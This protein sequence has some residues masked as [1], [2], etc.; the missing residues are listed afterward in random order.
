MSSFDI[1]AAES[2]D[3][4]ESNTN[5]SNKSSSSTCFKENLLGTTKVQKIK[6]NVRKRKKTVADYPLLKKEWHP[7]KN[8]NLH[9]EKITYGSGKKVWWLC[10]TCRYEW[11]ARIKNRTR[12]NGTGCPACAGQAVSELNSLTTHFPEVAKEWHP[13]K[14]GNLIPKQFTCGSGKKIWWLCSICGYEWKAGIKSRTNGTGCPAC[15]GQVVTEKN[16]LTMKQPHLKKEWHPDKNGN[17]TP[18]NFSFKSKKKVWWQCSTCEYEWEA[19]IKDRTNGT[20]CPACGGQVVTDNNRLSIKK[21]QL[22]KEWHPHKNGDLTPEKVSYGSNK[23]VWWLCSI[24]GHEWKTKIKDR[25]R[26]RGCPKRCRIN[27]SKQKKTVANYPLLKKEWHQEL[28]GDFTPE[29]VLYGSD[30]K[31]WWLCSVCGYEW[32]TKIRIRTQGKNCPKRCRNSKGERKKTVISYALLKKEWH[33]KKNNDLDPGKITYRSGRSV[34]WLCSLC[35]HEWKAKVSNRTNGTG[36]PACALRKGMC[37]EL[38][39]KWEKFCEE[40][41]S[42]LYQNYRFQFTGIKGIKPD[43]VIMEDLDVVIHTNIEKFDLIV[44]AKTNASTNKISETIKKYTPYCKRLE[45]W[46]LF[47]PQESFY[48][49]NIPVVFISPQELLL[50]IDNK[51]ERMKL[52]EKLKIII[53]YTKNPIDPTKQPLIE[54]TKKTQ[55]LFSFLGY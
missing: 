32:K 26:G 51:L 16:R 35:G 17:L 39:N 38:P 37:G 41:A 54:N 46:Y 4:K 20:G 13:N 25:A 40:V 47:N 31:V 33:P 22:K 48:Y 30:R 1:I 2:Y 52:E 10:A 29:K 23:K 24:C 5:D 44:D 8:R 43:I 3:N 50:R 6:N 14:N 53:G 45:L 55:E 21:P 28:N 9:S 27:K 42:L 34:W 36:C 11:K 49:N 7:N 19:M 18:E 12:K 15:A